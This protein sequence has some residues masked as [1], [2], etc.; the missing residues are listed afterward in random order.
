MSI[1]TSPVS[2]RYCHPSRLPPHRLTGSCRPPS[3]QQ[4]NQYLADFPL[5]RQTCDSLDDIAYLAAD[6]QLPP[7]EAAAAREVQRLYDSLGS[8]AESI[9]TRVLY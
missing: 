6:L 7:G 2:S 1:V 4:I 9:L 5:R 3:F 8:V